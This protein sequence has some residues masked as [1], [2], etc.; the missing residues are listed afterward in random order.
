MLSGVLLVFFFFEQTAAFDVRLSLLGSEIFIGY[1]SA[2]LPVCLPACLSICLSAY[3]PV[4]LCVCL[5]V[6]MSCLLYTS[7]AADD[8]LCVDIGGRLILKTQSPVS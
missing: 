4:C 3:L 5:S 7:D 6:C 2:C 1:L 8:L